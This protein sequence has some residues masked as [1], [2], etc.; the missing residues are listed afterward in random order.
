MKDLVKIIE[1]ALKR[2]TETDFIEFKEAS[3]NIP[4]DIWKTVSAFSHNPDGGIIV[5]GVHE[6]KVSRKLTPVGSTSPALLQENFTS[7]IHEKMKNCGSFTITIVDIN[8]VS[9]VVATINPISNEQKPCYFKDLGLPNGA[10]IREG[11]TNRVITDIEMKNFIRNSSVFKFDRTKAINID[12]NEI[13]RD[14]V[15]TL[16]EK[17]SNRT[18]RTN[19][20]NNPTDENLIN[21][22]ILG[23]FNGTINPTVAGI[24]IFSKRD[25]QNFLDYSRYVI[26][27]IRYQGNNVATEIIDSQDI[28]GTLDSQ[29]ENVHKFI[30]RNIR[31]EAFIIGT[32]REEKYEY[33]EDALREL[34]ANAII[35]RDY[36]ISE[37]YTQIAIFA[38]RIEISN[39]GNLPPGITIENLKEAQFSRNEVIAKILKDLDYME[40][41]GRGIDLVFAKMKEQLLPE[42][43]FQNISNKFT[44]K[45][46]GAVY[47]DLNTRQWKILEFIQNKK[48]SSANDI[49][50]SFGASASRATIYNDLAK[51]TKKELITLSKVDSQQYYSLNN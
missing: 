49:I 4:N 32:K 31:K 13:N 21:L 48:N 11:N 44:V 40:E 15:K 12:S 16:L 46:L 33:P 5:F 22:G 23:R 25:P 43:L 39:P 50:T 30:L 27:C 17:S 3:I 7:F 2:H 20:D 24:L 38:N 45:L 8:S 1:T 9:L 28:H 35:H 51:L 29:I 6:D 36:M 14:K 47:R 42:P 37:T 19:L 26:R 41:Y 10:C 34:V 18:N